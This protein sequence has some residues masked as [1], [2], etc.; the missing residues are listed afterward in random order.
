M[1]TA[2]SAP[3]APDDLVTSDVSFRTPD[4]I[5]LG[6]TVFAPRGATGRLPALL[7]VHGSGTG[8]PGFRE[9]LRG[10]AEAFARQ[11]IVVLAPDKRQDGYSRF[12]RDF[13]QLADDAL[14]AFAVLRDRPEVDPT[15]AGVWGL[16]EG[17][18]VAPMAA[19]KSPEVKFVIMAAGSGVSPVRQQSWNVANKFAWSG[20]GGSVA[21]TFPTTWHRM[22]SDAGLFGAAH[23]DPVPVLRAVRQPLLALYG[24]EDVAV[25]PAESAEIVR[26]TLSGAGNHHY[27]IRFIPNAPHAMHRSDPQGRRLPDLMP[28]YADAVGDW[29]DAV[30][31]GN[32]PRA[33]VE[34][35]PPQESRSTE[36]IR[37]AWW[38]SAPVQFGVLGLF[39]LLFGAYPV[40]FRKGR[41]GTWP[42]RVVVVAGLV[43]SFGT[44]GYLSTLM[45]SLTEY[46]VQAGPLLGDRPVVWLALQLTAVAATVAAVLV[47]LRWRASADR[48][49]QGLVLAGG[50]LFVPWAFYWG[51]L[52]P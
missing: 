52:L 9:Q 25:P 26:D 6:G 37:S 46:G 32:P 50:A 2:P 21:R 1:P 10:E 11:G 22:I 23:H 15:K 31:S 38:E 24:A 35:L 7:L 27:T 8:G 33:V 14:A 4:G 17:G 41:A 42:A 12:D 48:L 43:G 28:G 16:S 39:V 30:T 40:L 51:L 13:A 5:T 3:T 44:V 19:A 18:W 49:R 47:A 20:V 45:F 34:T 29:V 36:V